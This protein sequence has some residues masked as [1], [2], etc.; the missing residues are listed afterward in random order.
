MQENPIPKIPE[1]AETLASSSSI[2]AMADES[3]PPKDSRF[4]P[5]FLKKVYNSEIDNTNLTSHHLLIIAVHSVFLESGFIAF[6]PTS[7]I[8]GIRLPKGWASMVATSTVC[9]RYTLPDLVN[10]DRDSCAETAILKFQILGNFVTVYGILSLNSSDVFRI[11]LDV[12]RFVPSIDFVLRNVEDGN[13]QTVH[14]KVVFEFWK[15]VK[16]GLSLPLLISLCDK[17]G[18]PPPPCFTILPVDIKIRILDFLLGIDIARAACVY[19]E[20]RYLALNDDL[21]RK[22]L[23]EEFGEIHTKG[24]NA[25]HWKE[26]FKVCWQRRKGQ[27]MPLWQDR[28]L[29]FPTRRPDPV[30]FGAPGFPI[31]GGDYDRLP[32]ILG[33]VPFAPRRGFPRFPARWN[34]SPNCNL[35][36]FNV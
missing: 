13:L 14:E 15:I 5:H 26:N 22:K 29:Y 9:I 6:D 7:K 19:S 24:L 17:T 4:V 2:V 10:S 16:D 20:L 36:G 11:F 25:G 8:D 3:H 35:G 12:S 1:E 28:R 32:A 31:F 34:F 23:G 18:L 21:W 30:P 33:D 27:M